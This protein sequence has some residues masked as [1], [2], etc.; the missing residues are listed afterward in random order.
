MR[1]RDYEDHLTRRLCWVCHVPTHRS[2]QAQRQCPRCRRKWSYKR[3]EIQLQLIRLFATGAV[4]PKSA[5]DQLG[6]AYQTAWAHFLQFEKCLRHHSSDGARS[7]L[8][9]QTMRLNK[10]WSLAASR[11]ERNIIAETLFAECVRLPTIS[12][13]FASPAL[14]SC[15][16]KERSKLPTESS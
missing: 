7:F 12:T 4:R 8:R 11:A 6:I 3:R 2:N 9:F 1:L 15:L 13:P 10:Q 14:S 16:R 5:A